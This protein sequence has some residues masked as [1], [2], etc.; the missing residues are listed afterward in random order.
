MDDAGLRTAGIHAWTSGAIGTM[1]LAVMTRATRGHSG[2]ALRS[3]ATTTFVIYVPIV[4]AAALRIGA[5]L[6]PEFTMILLPLAGSYGSL[7]SS[8][9]LHSMRR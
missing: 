9:S 4:F 6:A 2:Q 7:P 5:A 3:P 8:A 1:T